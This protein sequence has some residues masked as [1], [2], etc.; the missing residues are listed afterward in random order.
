MARIDE[1]YQAITRGDV[2][3][4][5][6]TLALF[7][8][9]WMSRRATSGRLE[10]ERRTVSDSPLHFTL[11]YYYSGVPRWGHEPREGLDEQ[12][13]DVLEAL[14]EAGC[15]PDVRADDGFPSALVL[16]VLFGF[17]LATRTLLEHGASVDVCFELRE[18]VREW[19]LRAPPAIAHIKEEIE[20][21]YW[22][23]SRHAYVGSLRAFLGADIIPID[24]SISQLITQHDPPRDTPPAKG[25]AGRWV[26]VAWAFMGEEEY[27]GYDLLSQDCT[28]DRSPTL[29]GYCG[30]SLQLQLD[31]EVELVIDDDGSATLTKY[32]TTYLLAEGTISGA[33]FHVSGLESLTDNEF[34]SMGHLKRL[35][36]TP[37]ELIYVQHNAI[38]YMA[39]SAC[40]AHWSILMRECR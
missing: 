19:R 8:E 39:D 38:G 5:R 34:L 3:A 4:V 26:E 12:C 29:G 27:G 32:M 31:G 14:L 33:E 2:T 20:G 18:V 22:D 25:L 17:K 6:T 1:L 36:S 24:A 13:V 40:A 16:S 10:F 35:E 9:A 37:H 11:L 15:E 28:T 30:S 21:Y 7:D 23:P